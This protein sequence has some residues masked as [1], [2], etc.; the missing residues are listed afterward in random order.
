MGN[1]TDT[2]KDFNKR[3]EPI[4]KRILVGSPVIT[5][6]LQGDI[7]KAIQDEL[8]NMRFEKMQE[9]C[10]ITNRNL[11]CYVSAWLQSNQQNPELSINDN[12]MNGFMNAIPTLDKSKGLDLFLHTPG[13]VV[14]ATESIVKYLRKIFHGDIRVIVPHMSMSAGTMIACASNEIIMGK[15]S[16]LGPIDP[17]YRGVPAQGVEKE[18]RQALDETVLSPN[19]SLIWKEIISQYRPTFVGECKN[20]VQL[21]DDLVTDW[22]I[23][24]MFKKSVNKKEKAKKVMDELLNHDASKV[25]DRHYDFVRCK[26]LGLKVTPLEG[27]QNLQDK[28]LSLYH[29]YFLSIYRLPNALKFIENQN[30]QAIMLSG[31]R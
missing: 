25:H 2:E 23:T 13:G 29:L 19:K 3:I 24:G 21:A 7:N 26:Q 16:S 30:G 12:D 31:I 14:T 4:V 28:V 18:F 20:V 22:L 1:F 27:N 17:Q 11:I 5:P 10:S 15:E 9:I 6:Q 8:A